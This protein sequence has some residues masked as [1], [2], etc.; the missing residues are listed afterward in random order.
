MQN[1]KRNIF[2]Y[3]KQDELITY[4][5]LD[6]NSL[7]SGYYSLQDKTLTKINVSRFKEKNKL[8][9]DIVKTKTIFSE[10]CMLFHMFFDQDDSYCK[11]IKKGSSRIGSP[12]V[13][14][15]LHSFNDDFIES[16]TINP[17]LVESWSKKL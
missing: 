6:I 9:T 12:E 16:Y 5:E 8:Q 3:N 13:L 4:V 10:D 11:V 2:L 15:T 14:S 1:C 17:S 7:I